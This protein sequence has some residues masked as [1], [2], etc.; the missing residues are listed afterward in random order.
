MNILAYLPPSSPHH[1]FLIV[2]LILSPQCSKF[3]VVA[4]STD[5]STISEQTAGPYWVSE[6]INKADLRSD[7][8]LGLPLDL[9]FRV[10]DA[11]RSSLDS[12]CVPVGHARIDIWHCSH[13][14]LYSDESILGTKGQKWLRGYQITNES[15]YAS[16]YTIFPGWYI[17]RTVHVHLRVRL[18]SENGTVS[19]D[20]FTQIYFD[21]AITDA[22]F[23]EVYPYNARG[24]KRDTNNSDDEYFT[25][26][27][28]VSLSGSPEEGGYRG[29]MD[30]RVPFVSGGPMDSWRGGVVRGS[31]ARGGVRA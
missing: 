9:T 17:H 20:D 16:F 14:G 24:E 7:I 2:L 3:Y 19:Y 1:V 29:T 22:I 15:G 10:V 27:N 25:S 12:Y 6:D 26:N 21:D 23:Q 11:R 5:C 4:K 28:K 13:D 18:Y 31:S 30:L 8:S